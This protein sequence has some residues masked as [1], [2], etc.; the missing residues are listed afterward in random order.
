MLRDSKLNCAERSPLARSAAAAVILFCGLF[1]IG[2]RDP[3]AQSSAAIGEAFAA[4]P[5][6]PAAKVE[7]TQGA[8]GQDII[9]EG[10]GWRNLQLGT[11]REDLIHSLGQPDS[12]STLKWLKWSQLHIDCLLREDTARVGEIRFNPGFNGALANGLQVGSP[13]QKITEY[14]SEKPLI[15]SRDS[16]AT[17]YIYPAKGILFW[18]YQGAITQIVVFP[19]Q[20]QP[21]ASVTKDGGGDIWLEMSKEDL[22]NS[23]GQPDS[24][25]TSNWLKWSQLHIDCLF[26]SG[27]PGITEIRLNPGF[28]G[29]I[30]K[31]V[32]VGSPVD[33]A[34]QLFGDKPDFITTRDGGA[35]KYEYSTKG[36]LFWMYGGKV[37]QVVFF[38]PY[39]P[40]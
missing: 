33:Q 37:S 3:G 35:T 31:G 14:Y 32:K 27:S 12:D 28:E 40:K 30:G 22:V 15:T 38:K 26:T 24:D 25:S 19:Q 17:K 39:N 9:V 16:G 34:I 29:E 10:S 11:L 20:S 21:K 2:L 36:V 5:L 18:T 6:P 4:A 1:A 13:A 23:L 8:A 7:A